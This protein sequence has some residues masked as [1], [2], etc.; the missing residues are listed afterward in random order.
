MFENPYVVTNIVCEMKDEWLLNRELELADKYPQAINAQEIQQKF[1]A[2]L[3]IFDGYSQDH[4]IWYN[5]F[6]TIS[7]KGEV[8]KM[9]FLAASHCFICKEVE[10]AI[11]Q[12]VFTPAEK[13]NK[14]VQ[15]YIVVK[16]K[17]QLDEK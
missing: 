15:S 1:V 9:N 10:N 12:I 5:Y 7:E 8:V 3:S 4:D 11:S 14:Q 16:F 13:D 6:V 17:F 2:P